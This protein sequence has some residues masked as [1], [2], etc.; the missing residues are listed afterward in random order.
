MERNAA[1]S[2]DSFDRAAAAF[3]VIPSAVVQPVRGLEE[4]LG[5][6]LVALESL[7]R[8]NGIGMHVVRA[9]PPSSPVNMANLAIYFVHAVV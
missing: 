5:K 6:I 2:E 7:L 1:I 3:G 8:A 9:P 4:R